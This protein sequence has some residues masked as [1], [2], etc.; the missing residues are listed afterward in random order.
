MLKSTWSYP[1]KVESRNKKVTTRRVNK[2][3][4]MPLTRPFTAYS[5]AYGA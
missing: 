5:A 1:P 2:A 3:G 4:K